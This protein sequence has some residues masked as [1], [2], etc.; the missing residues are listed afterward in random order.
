M[1]CAACDED[2]HVLVY[3]RKAAA[4]A[5]GHVDRIEENGVL[6]IRRRRFAT[7]HAHFSGHELAQSGDESCRGE[8]F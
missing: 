7:L 2:S 5:E 3:D 4:P 6:V 8:A 1:A